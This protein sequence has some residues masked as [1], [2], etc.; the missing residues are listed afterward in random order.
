[1]RILVTGGA[2][3]IGGYLVQRLID[4]GD[5][6]TIVDNLSTGRQENVH[7]KASFIKEDICTI[8]WGEFI[9]EFDEIY[10][11]A[12]VVG[13]KQV[14]NNP[15]ETI[16]TNMTGTHRLLEAM[17][18]YNPLAKLFVASTSE[19][20]GKNDKRGLTEEDDR[21]TGSTLKDRWIYAETKA[22]DE[23]L[24]N[25]YAREHSLNCL[26][27]RFFSIVGGNQLS[28]YGMV[29]PNFI[30]Q[31]LQ[32]APITVYGDGTQ[33]RSF[34]DV[35]DCVDCV[36][37]LV[38]KHNYKTTEIVNIGNPEPVMIKDLAWRIKHLTNSK[39]E[40]TYVPYNEAYNKGFEDMMW[41][42]PNI[43]K[44]NTLL[45]KQSFR[46]LDTILKDIIEFYKG[47]L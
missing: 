4:N 5:E 14:L 43:D 23:F 45:G 32:E 7:P 31:A 3:F 37:E 15:L 27:A 24:V 28:E 10:H 25:L 47:E 34:M 41:R 26:I 17:I 36:F 35:R 12:A 18:M 33:V 19:V 29:I 44:L 40:I 8:N 13:V 38:R 21:I 46:N 2:G 20:Y 42:T 9:H 16:H 1:M 22:M 11:L 30:E 6:V 39:S